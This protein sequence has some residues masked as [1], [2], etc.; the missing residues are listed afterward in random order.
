LIRADEVAGA[1]LKL[2]E[3]SANDTNGE[4][5]ILDGKDTP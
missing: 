4:L 3:D 5:V 1:I 2:C